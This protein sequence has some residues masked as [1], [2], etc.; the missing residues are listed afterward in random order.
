MHF[1]FLVEEPSME[2]ALNNL[3]PKILDL[4]TDSYSIRTFQGK[5]DLLSK[6]PQRLQGYKQYLTEN[7][8]I[9]VLVDRDNDDCIKLKQ[10]LEKFALDAQLTTKSSVGAAGLFI[11]LNRIVIEELESWFLGDLY[12]IKFAFPDIS[13][14]YVTKNKNLNPDEIPKPSKKLELVLQRYQYYINGMPKIE[15]AEKI[16]EHMIPQR[17]KSK[18]FQVFYSGL[19]SCYSHQR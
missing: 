17:N 11:V 6:L 13:N 5:F 10:K 7:D 1:E 18:S 3:L 2:S 4:N 19:R 15:V 8:R 14:N 12:A 9:A 16:S